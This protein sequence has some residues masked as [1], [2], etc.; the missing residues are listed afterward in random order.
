[1]DFVASLDAGVQEHLQSAAVFKGTS[2]TG[3]NEFLDCM[4][5]GLRE[6]TTEEIRNADCVLRC[7]RI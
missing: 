6:H 3:H 5:S 4:L 1:M 7:Q 2:E